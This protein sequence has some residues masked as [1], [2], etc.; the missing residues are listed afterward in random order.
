MALAAPALA[1]AIVG[2]MNTLMGPAEDP[3]A[4]LNFATALANAIVAHIQSSATV[5]GIATD[6]I[7]G[8]LPVTGTVG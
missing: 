6:P 3:A 8:P 7:S 5:T 1:T 4:R 2:Q